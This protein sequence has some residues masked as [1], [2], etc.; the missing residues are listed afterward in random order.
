[1]APKRRSLLVVLGVLCVFGAGG[2]VVALVGNISMTSDARASEH[3]PSTTGT[4][5][6]S[7]IV[8]QTGRNTHYYE[9]LARYEYE[10]EG[11]VHHGNQIGFYRTGNFDHA[12]D[13]RAFV[14]HYQ[15][16]ARVDVYYDPADPERAV[17][18]R[19]GPGT[20]MG[21]VVLFASMTVA[22]VVGAVAC[23]VRARRAGRRSDA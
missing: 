14:A 21:V 9:V 10:V 4:M 12:S 3:W 6:S 8:T 18:V 20:G 23:F 19:G 13:A 16:G 5:L 17:L 7:D 2:G 22:F 15:P 11:A 1:M